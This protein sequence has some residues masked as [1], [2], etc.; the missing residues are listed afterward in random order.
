MT[1]KAQL[2]AAFSSALPIS[3]SDGGEK[4]QTIVNYLNSRT[5]QAW[6]INEF[7]LLARLYPDKWDQEKKQWK[8][9]SSDSHPSVTMALQ[10]RR[11]A[12]LFSVDYDKKTGLISISYLDKDP[13]FAKKVVAGVITELE[14]Y[15]L[16][17]N[18]TDAKR[19]RLFVEEQ[20]AR[21]TQ[22]L[23][24]WEKQVPSANLTESTVLREQR[25]LLVVY[26]E[27]KKQFE[28]AK[29]EEAKQVVAFKVLDEPLVPE[30]KDKP[31][32]RLI[33]LGTLM[34]SGLF[35]IML[36]FVFEFIKSVMPRK[37]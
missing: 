36:V 22:E 5:M 14:R 30:L 6:M 23:E 18:V 33:C 2:L 27:L 34:F 16:H 8:N 3:I 17:D 11:L 35:A 21:T 15:L 12:K 29:I 32:R 19:N 13:L 20:V 7:N 37:K 4:T 26:T 31:N 28:L 10:R 24:Y 1:K 25:A 9:A